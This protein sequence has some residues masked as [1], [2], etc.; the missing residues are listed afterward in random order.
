MPSY[1][2][3]VTIKVRVDPLAANPDRE[4]QARIAARA[5][6]D[7]L[8]NES[9][10]GLL[11]HCELERIEHPHLWFVISVRVA[12]AAEPDPGELAMR[13]DAIVKTVQGVLDS[14]A[15]SAPGLLVH[16][17]HDLDDELEAIQT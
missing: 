2:L 17:A 15:P 1:R 8:N 14:D 9:A 12:F 10:P 4:V 3:E 16:W 6:E 13:R 11:V 5:L 7:A